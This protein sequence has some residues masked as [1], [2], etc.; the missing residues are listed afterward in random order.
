[1][2]HSSRARS[3]GALLGINPF[4]QPDV[5]AAKAAT[6]EVL[7]S[8]ADLPPTQDATAA[9][10][11]LTEGDYLALLGYVVPD[12]DDEAALHDAAARL[13]LRTGVPVTVGVGPRYLHSTGQLH[14]GGPAGGTFLVVVGADP[15]DAEIPGRPYTFSRLKR[16]QAAGDIDALRAAGRTV[17]HVTP[18][19]L[20]EL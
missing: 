1:V 18:A 5:Q 10:D 13:R 3:P 12:G 14:K 16:A 11:A 15:E 2:S 19:H 4:D 8:G 7:E 6:A 17:L 20:A 9:V